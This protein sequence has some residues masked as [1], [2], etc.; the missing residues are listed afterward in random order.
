MYVVDERV[1]FPARGLSLSGVLSYPEAREPRGAVLVLSPHPSFAGHLDNNVVRAMAAELAAA[2]ALV[3][4]FDYHGVGESGIELP[5]GA[6]VLDYWR[7]I[8]DEARYGD[9]LSDARAAERF[10]S[11]VAGDLPAHRVGYSFG[12]L[13]AALCACET[14]AEPRA[15]EW[16]VGIAPP[17]TR[18]RFDFLAGCSRRKAFF[19]AGHDFLYGEAETSELSGWLAPGDRLEVLPDA[20]H[21][22]RGE[23]GELARRVRGVLLPQQEPS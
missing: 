6:S 20:D 10:L 12:A 2:G 17:L 21:F 1:H 19:L 4:R 13:I 15:G 23:E 9:V 7:R 18:A 8:E 3:L 5:P 22:F 16:L 14:P 11:G